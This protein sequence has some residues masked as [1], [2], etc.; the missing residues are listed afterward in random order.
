MKA[1]YDDIPLSEIPD[2]NVK[3]WRYM[4]FTKFASMLMNKALFFCRVSELDDPWEGSYS[5]KT[6]IWREDASSIDGVPIRKLRH[7]EFRH[8]VLVNCW[9]I[10]D[11]ESAALWKVYSKNNYGVALQSTFNRLRKS[12]DSK[13]D[14]YV[15]AWK[16]RYIDYTREYVPD[17]LVSTFP[18]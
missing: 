3:I 4:D 2:G 17:D 18:S 14:N 11:C 9:S 10:S 8:R 15:H 12:F 7:K 1:I 5:R 16:V 13:A 6:F